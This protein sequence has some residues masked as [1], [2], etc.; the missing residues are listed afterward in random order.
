MP[1]L[2][3][4]AIIEARLA[5]ECFLARPRQNLVGE[6]G[7]ASLLKTQRE[8]RLRPPSD[9]LVM[10]DDLAVE[11]FVALE[12]LRLGLSLIPNINPELTII[13]FNEVLKLLVLDSMP[14][15]VKRDGAVGVFVIARRVLRLRLVRLFRRSQLRIVL[16]HLELLSYLDLGITEHEISQLLLLLLQELFIWPEQ[17]LRAV[18]HFI[19][20]GE[21]ALVE[22]PKVVLLL[23]ATDLPQQLALLHPI[24]RPKIGPFVALQRF[25]RLLLEALRLLQIWRRFTLFLQRWLFIAFI[26]IVFRGLFLLDLDDVA[27][28][29]G[30]PREHERLQFLRRNHRL[31]LLLLPFIFQQLIEH[32]GLFLLLF[33]EL[34]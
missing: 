15:I 14:L 12:G 16:L 27:P 21:H 3:V 7:L 18:L 4:Q 17:R 33:S 8:A 34:P 25:V 11:C 22:V 26:G 29:L 1:L 2:V 6:L 32:V 23:E 9:C 19:F 5:A 28:L 30:V 24:F 31:H 20:S 13:A 10:R